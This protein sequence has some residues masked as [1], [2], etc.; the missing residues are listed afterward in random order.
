MQTMDRLEQIKNT[1]T[2]I[3]EAAKPPT[4]EETL[5]RHVPPALYE[6]GDCYVGHALDAIESHT[7]AHTATLR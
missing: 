5:K 4:A 3:E 2:A 1:V 6:R 7:S